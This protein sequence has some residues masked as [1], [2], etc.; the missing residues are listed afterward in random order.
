MNWPP[1]AWSLNTLHK[2]IS[3]CYRCACQ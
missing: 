1:L 3:Y 2:V